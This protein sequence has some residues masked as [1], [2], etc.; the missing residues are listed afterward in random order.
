MVRT[1]AIPTA[2]VSDAMAAYTIGFAKLEVHERIEDAIGAGSGTLVSVGKVRGI[3]TA[4]H[5]LT[6][7]PDQGDVGIVEYRG[8]TIHYRKRT[9]EMANTTKIVLRGDGFGSDGPD[10]AFL[11]LAADTVGWFEAI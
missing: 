11:R 6:N 1:I 7:L 8:Q 2:G 3:L 10:L 4:A 9:I 5:V